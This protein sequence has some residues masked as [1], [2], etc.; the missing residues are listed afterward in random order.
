MTKNSGRTSDP[1]CL[2]PMT[3][4]CN[5]SEMYNLYFKTRK[6]SISFI[7]SARARAAPWVFDVVAFAS[8]SNRVLMKNDAYLLTEY[9]CF[10]NI[11]IF[12]V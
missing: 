2:D 11:F 12:I 3:D 4:K 6:N 1:L 5:V 10:V 9:L 8:I 7:P